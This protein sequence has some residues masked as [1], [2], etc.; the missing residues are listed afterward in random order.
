MASPHVH[1]EV[2]LPSMISSVQIGDLG[3]NRAWKLRQGMQPD[4]VNTDSENLEYDSMSILFSI[5]DE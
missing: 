4:P 1:V 3:Q 5:Y 2:A